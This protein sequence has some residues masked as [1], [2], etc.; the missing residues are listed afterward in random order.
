MLEMIKLIIGFKVFHSAILKTKFRIQEVI[1]LD[2]FYQI[3]ISNLPWTQ[4]LV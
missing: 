2:F 3:L 1:S 4:K